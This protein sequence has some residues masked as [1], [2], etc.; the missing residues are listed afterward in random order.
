MNELKFSI[1]IKQAV[2]LLTGL[3][4]AIDRVAE[5]HVLSP[6]WSTGLMIA[7]VVISSFLG[8]LRK[9]QSAPIVPDAPPPPPPAA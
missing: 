6:K 5:L 9:S 3:L 7:S 1:D 8:P 2:V 4:T